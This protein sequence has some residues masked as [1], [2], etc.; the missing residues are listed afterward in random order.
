MSPSAPPPTDVQEDSGDENVVARDTNKEKIERNEKNDEKGEKEAKDLLPLR[1]HCRR[2][3]VSYCDHAD[4]F[5]ITKQGVAFFQ[6]FFSCAFPFDSYD[7]VFVPEF[8]WGVRHR[9]S[10]P[11]SVVT[12]TN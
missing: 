9:T 6:Q 7:Q 10:L 11:L 3:L 12:L 5:A 1:I 8:N 2:S 4:L